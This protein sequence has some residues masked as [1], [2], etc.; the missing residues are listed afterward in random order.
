MG[1]LSAALPEAKRRLDGR[2]VAAHACFF[3]IT[4]PQYS[5]KA[6]LE[7]Q[8]ELSIREGGT[9]MTRDE[10]EIGRDGLARGLDAE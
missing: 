10:V 6:V 2:L 3:N 5:S 8:L 1:E 4:L 7:T 9:A